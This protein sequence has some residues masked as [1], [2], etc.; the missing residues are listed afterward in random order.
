MVNNF[1]ERLSGSLLVFFLAT[2]RTSAGSRRRPR[3]QS[4]W[5]HQRTSQS[6]DRR[7]PGPDR[8]PA[9]KRFPAHPWQL[10][11]MEQRLDR[12]TDKPDAIWRKLITS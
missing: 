8:E 10:D 6:R 11:V 2:A 3:T 1:K 7:G 4:L 5:G 12:W 9:R